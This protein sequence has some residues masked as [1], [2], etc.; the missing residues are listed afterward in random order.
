MKSILLILMLSL[1]SQLFAANL[2]LTFSVEGQVNKG[3]AVLTLNDHIEVF[4][5]E[6][7]DREA[8]K[9]NTLKGVTFSFNFDLKKGGK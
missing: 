5:E 4:Y 1:P 9:I 2:D 8:G 7:H 6:E 3:E